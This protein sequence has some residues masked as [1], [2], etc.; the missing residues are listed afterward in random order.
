MKLIEFV[1]RIFPDY[2]VLISTILFFIVALF[3]VCIHELYFDEMQAWLIAINS[4]SLLELFSNLRYEGHPPLWH[5]FL[6][7]LKHLSLDPFS[8]QVAS[9]L[10]SGLT[11]Y[12][13]LKYA[14]F[15]RIQRFLLVFGYFFLYQYGINAR[16]YV[17]GVLF[18]VL[19]CV[20]AVS[21][22]KNY[23]LLSMFLIL[24]S[25][26]SFVGSLFSIAF[27]VYLLIDFFDNNNKEIVGSNYAI[28]SFLLYLAGLLLSFSTM[29]HPADSDLTG[30][31]LGDAKVRYFFDQLYLVYFPDNTLDSSRISSQ[32]LVKI[33]S[34][35]LVFY[36]PIIFYT[37]K[38]VFLFYFIGNVLFILSFAFVKHCHVNHLG[39]LFLLLVVSWWF[40]PK[41]SRGVNLFLTTL[42]IIGFLMGI[43][44]LR[45]DVLRDFSA[46][47]KV[48]HFIKS[49][50]LNNLAIV[51]NDSAAAVV[52]G[53]LGRDIYYA[54]K[55][56]WGGF[57]K[58]DDKW[59]RSQF[60]A[61]RKASLLS[62]KEGADVLVILNRP[63]RNLKKF[64][65]IR[66]LAEFRNSIFE[67]AYVYL[68]MKDET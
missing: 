29:M 7:L 15:G 2:F 19:L 63:L 25:L 65:N 44:A 39:Y 36:L 67:H 51:A 53:Y 24:L 46:G 33:M 16:G 14:P 61:I 54:H 48:A 49:K 3:G 58:F 41:Q 34:I 10:I 8:M 12:L 30:W 32:F 59:R 42:L 31:F 56:S 40:F 37:R 57:I 18:I 9:V 45:I 38:A 1:R 4:H 13:V 66:K 5:I 17:L 47:K 23:L 55:D 26:T 50:N 27:F 21:Q 60:H 28:L 22:R 64:S 20:L 11:A 35:L 68:Y 52:S 43:E 6:F 62:L